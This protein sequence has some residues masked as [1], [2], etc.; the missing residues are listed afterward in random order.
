[1]DSRSLLLLATLPC[2]ACRDPAPVRTAAVAPA[3]APPAATTPMRR[4]LA[5]PDFMAEGLAWDA[6]RERLLLGGIVDQSIAAVARDGTVTRFA[7]TPQSWSVFGVG[8]DATRGW[9]WAACSAVPQGR[10]LPAAV[11]AAG[12]FAFSLDDG[13]L[14][15]ARTTTA[16]DG[17][18]HLF[19]DLAI[20][21][22]GRV[23][24]TDSI[25]GG[26]YRASATEAALRELA[27]PQSF[28]SA[29]GLVVLDDGALLVADYS[30]GLVH[31]S[32]DAGAS[33][34]LQP[35]AVPTDADL[36]GI[37]GMA[38]RGRTVIAVQNGANPPRVL[39]LTLSAGHDA[40]EAAAILLEPAPA[41]GEPTLA[42]I[43]GDEVWITQTDRWDRVFGPAAR[44]RADVTI[45]APVG[46]RARLQ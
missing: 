37:D 19:G 31:A 12:L 45:A 29:Q 7:A 20:A 33:A 36:R 11:G 10:T 4:A 15:H 18:Q 42:T 8:I 21:D 14:V 43:V 39:Q 17:A 1:V 3:A 32:L 22:D 16:D 2:A 13:A 46:V 35:M 24:T 38:R 25:G 26:L 41:D 23:Y 6:P 40:I 30:R 5:L 28:R 34:T 27:P 44:P 9:V